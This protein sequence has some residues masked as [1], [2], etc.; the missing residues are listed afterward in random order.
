ME[1]DKAV[2]DLFRLQVPQAE[3]THARGVNHIAAVR[4]VIQA[5][6]G[7]GVLAQPETS[8]TSLVRISC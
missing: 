6:R 3:L 2:K 5:R 7:G 8:D 1:F 4:E